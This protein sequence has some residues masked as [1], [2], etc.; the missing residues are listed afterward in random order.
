M[1]L[2]HQRWEIELGFR[3]IKSSMLNNAITLRSKKAE[4]VYQELWGILLAYN[5]V[6]REASHAAA[7]HDQRAKDIRFKMAYEYI[8]ANLIVMAGVTPESKTGSR[9]KDLRP[10]ICNLF[11][12][13]R[14]SRPSRPRRVKISKTRYPVN[15]NA[16]PLK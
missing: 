16:A 9:L 6:R 14:R 4:L 8:A 12:G 5:L 11:L 13:E 7:S 10:G 3:D 15:R 2:Y 1:G